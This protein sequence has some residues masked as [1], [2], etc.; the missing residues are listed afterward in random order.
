MDPHEEEEILEPKELIKQFKE[1][2]HEYNKE[3]EQTLA[4]ILELLDED[5]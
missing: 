4:K 5:N 2:R 3:I 1:K